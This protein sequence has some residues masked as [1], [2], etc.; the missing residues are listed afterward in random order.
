MP[1]PN[2]PLNYLRQIAIGVATGLLLL[3]LIIGGLTMASTGKSN[4]A[5]ESN[6][7]TDSPTVSP[8]AEGRDCSVVDL[9]S[10]K[11]LVGL[12]AQVLN[13]A[14]NEVLFDI[15][16]DTPTQTASVMK[17]LTAAAALQVLGPNY[18][19]ETKVYADLDNPGQIVFVGAG[20]PT[21]SRT[22]IGKDSVYVGAPKVGA[23]LSLG[24]I[25]LGC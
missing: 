20:D 24:D 9:A 19:V 7:P 21:L 6:S 23:S 8:T 10:D 16:G 25:C 1:S 11:R 15:M 17:L 22:G 4:T 3:V 2:S 13:P 14:T 5:T 18:R 12:H